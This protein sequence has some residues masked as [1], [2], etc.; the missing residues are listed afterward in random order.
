MIRGVIFDMDGL[1][2]DTERVSAELW[3]QAG[4]ELGIPITP[5]FVD[6][7]RGRNRQVIQD[8]FQK[9]FGPG[10]AWKEAM[11][12]KRRLEEAYYKTHEVPVKKGLHELLEYLQANAY[13]AAV[14]TSTDRRLAEHLLG[15]AEVLNYFDNIV[16]GDTVK[17]SKPFPDI[18]QKAAAELRLPAEECLILEDSTAGVEAG[19]ASGS[20]VIHIPDLQKVPPQVKAG[21]DAEYESLDQVIGWLQTQRA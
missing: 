16:Y 10:S 4:Q 21:I 2:F 6:R 3:G 8:I 5:E 7:F 11:A 12:A 19:K 15:N 17:R 13:R 18:F 14:A 1:M 20:H 9:T